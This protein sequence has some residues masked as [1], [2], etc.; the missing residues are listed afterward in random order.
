MTQLATRKEVENV[1]VVDAACG[2]DNDTVDEETTLVSRRIDTVAV[3]KNQISIYLLDATIRFDL[4]SE[5]VK[6]ALEK[7]TSTYQ[8]TKACFKDRFP[9]IINIQK[10]PQK[11]VS[12]VE[13][14]K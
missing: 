12:Y 5:K 7:K 8:P 1:D 10:Q 2:K 6:D 3:A 14:G 11:L 9:G 13:V 4:T